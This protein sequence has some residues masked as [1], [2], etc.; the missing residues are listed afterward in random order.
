[1]SQGPGNGTIFAMRS[2]ATEEAESPK[3]G[4][5]LD[6]GPAKDDAGD[7]ASGKKSPSE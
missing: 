7:K 1:M 5:A 3:G 4:A 2:G 6:A